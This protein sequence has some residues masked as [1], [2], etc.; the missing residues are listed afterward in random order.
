LFVL[1]VSSPLNMSLVDSKLEL[2]PDC[3][4]FMCAITRAR[5]FSESEGGAGG[6]QRDHNLKSSVRIFFKLSLVSTFDLTFP[7][8]SSSSSSSSAAAAAVAA[9]AAA[10]HGRTNG[11]S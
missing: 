4:R 2:T 5:E 11:S 9:A 8:P 7:Y 10:M 1:L 3:D 6:M